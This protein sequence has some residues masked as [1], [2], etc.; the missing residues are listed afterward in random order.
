MSKYLLF[1]SLFL[2]LLCAACTPA[3]FPATGAGPLATP[4]ADTVRASLVAVTMTATPPPTVDIIGTARADQARAQK[5]SDAAAVEIAQ[6]ETQKQA[7]IATVVAMTAIDDDRTATQ[8]PLSTAAAGTEQARSDTRLAAQAT[9]QAAGYTATAALPTQIVAAANARAEA[10]NAPLLA[11]GR[12]IGP[13]I[14]GVVVVL[15]ALTLTLWAYS[16]YR[17]ALT[18]PRDYVPPEMPNMAVTTPTCSATVDRP[19]IPRLDGTLDLDTQP[20]GDAAKFTA[21]ADY[22]LRGQPL[23]SDSVIKFAHIYGSYNQYNPVRDWLKKKEYILLGPDGAGTLS[24]SGIE[25]CTLWTLGHPLPAASDPQKQLSTSGD[26][27]NG[28]PNTGG[29]VGLEPANA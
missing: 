24:K 13:V 12:A 9:E 23:G 22:A 3:D 10:D 16:R 21:Y 19:V 29:G 1:V 27:N 15:L 18:W 4:Q 11:F 20:P 6:A 25:F 8:A 5:T 2:F 26:N 7:L 14:L 17:A 28:D